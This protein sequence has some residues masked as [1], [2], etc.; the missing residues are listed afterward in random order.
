MPVSSWGG[1]SFL[2]YYNAL[3]PGP[4]LTAESVLWY[5]DFANGHLDTVTG[6][7]GLFSRD[8]SIYQW[9][10]KQFIERKRNQHRVVP[11]THWNG[12]VARG[13][14]LSPAAEQQIDLPLEFSSGDWDDFATDVTLQDIDSLFVGQVASRITGDKD[15]YIT[16]DLQDS[17]SG[18]KTYTI[19][20]SQ[21]D[22]DECRF[23]VWD[24]TTDTY[25]CQSALSFDEGTCTTTAGTGFSRAVRLRDLPRTYIA[26]V[27]F[28]APSGHDL[29]VDFTPTKATTGEYTTDLHYAGVVLGQAAAIVAG[30]L[31]TVTDVESIQYT[32]APS[33]SESIWYERFVAGQGIDLDGVPL[34]IGSDYPYFER[35]EMGDTVGCRLH[36]TAEEIL[37]ASVE[38][39]WQDGD[40]VELA[41]ILALD[42]DDPTLLNLRFVVRVNGEAA[43]DSGVNQLEAELPETWGGDPYLFLGDPLKPV[44]RDLERVYC[45]NAGDT[46][47]P[48]I[49]GDADTL[50]FELSGLVVGY[51]REILKVLRPEQPAIP[52]PDVLFPI[53]FVTTEDGW[54]ID[55]EDAEPEGYLILSGDDY[56][57]DTEADSG[58][59]I[60][61]LDGV[62]YFDD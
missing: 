23:R 22:S 59:P 16:H 43:S 5:K 13:I 31:N 3:I 4:G 52:S 49:Y 12:T 55:T 8:S 56:V 21:V 39:E 35:F 10:S 7:N 60:T 1:Y 30:P 18:L 26:S 38:T 19:I 24:E 36:L 54:A 44:S 50:L 14:S 42:E 61:V 27:T 32:V 48:V 11:V 25:I 2:S 51:N 20:V 45:A 40:D 37:A 29:W 17:V 6:N 62:P 34:L 33:P 46:Y 58:L 47:T 53:Y 28:T 9:N 41:S 57:I 15:S